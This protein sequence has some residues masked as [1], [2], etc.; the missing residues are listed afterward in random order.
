MLPSVKTLHSNSNHRQIQAEHLRLAEEQVC[1]RRL[2]SRTAVS[3]RQSIDNE[4]DAPTKRR[5]GLS[6][7]FA[8]QLVQCSCHIFLTRAESTSPRDSS[9]RQITS[10]WD[11]HVQ[12]REIQQRFLQ[13]SFRIS[14]RRMS[15]DS[16]VS[17]CTQTVSGITGTN[18]PQGVLTVEV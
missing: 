3:I 4:F 2:Q 5:D 7:P 14:D 9:L 13:R 8:T 17:L 12:P 16:G 6:L 11:Q 10:P 18:T 15:R 1:V